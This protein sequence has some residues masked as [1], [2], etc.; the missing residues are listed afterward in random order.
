MASELFSMAIYSN[1]S[2]PYFEPDFRQVLESHLEYLKVTGQYRTEIVNNKYMGQYIGDFYAIL[3]GMQINARYHWI[4]MR[5][6]GFTSPI[7]YSGQ[8]LEI[9]IPDTN[10]IDS[11]Y[12][13]YNTGKS[14]LKLETPGQ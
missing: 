6:N 3:Q 2:A 4:V 13:V 11:I 9:F 12:S 7:Q 10:V 1:E 5:L 14:K 8:L